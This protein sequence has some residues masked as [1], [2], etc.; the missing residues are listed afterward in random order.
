MKKEEASGGGGTRIKYCGCRCNAGGSKRGA[1]YQDEKYGAGMRVFNW[2]GK[3][4]APISV[5][6]R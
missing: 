4:K 5:A 2:R 3:D 6:A 1:V